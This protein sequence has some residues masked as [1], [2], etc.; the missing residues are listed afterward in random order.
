LSSHPITNPQLKHYEIIPLQWM[1]NG[2]KG[3]IELLIDN[4]EPLEGA[5]GMSARAT[6]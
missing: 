5:L 1:Q 3:M 4:Y 2:R 6:G